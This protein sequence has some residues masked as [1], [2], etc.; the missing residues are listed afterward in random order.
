MTA[1]IDKANLCSNEHRLNKA[2]LVSVIL[3][4]TSLID[5]ANLCSNEHRLKKPV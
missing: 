5:I 3:K 1:L 2:G 4:E